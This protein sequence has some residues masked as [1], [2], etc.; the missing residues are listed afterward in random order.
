[1]RWTGM[2]TIDYFMKVLGILNIGR[3]QSLA[4]LNRV[5]LNIL[6]RLW[7]FKFIVK[8]GKKAY[9]LTVLIEGWAGNLFTLWRTFLGLIYEA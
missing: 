3:F 9:F 4:R 8:C 7:K 2:L 6:S 5:D 1:M